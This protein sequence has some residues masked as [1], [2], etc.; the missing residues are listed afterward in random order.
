MTGEVFGEHMLELVHVETQEVHAEAEQKNQNQRNITLESQTKH[1]NYYYL[2]K[3]ILNYSVS[4]FNKKHYYFIISLF[5]YLPVDP[6]PPPPRA[7]SP[8]KSASESTI[9][10]L[11]G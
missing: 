3:L 5:N 4:D 2:C 6:N 11:I 9:S 8:P 1:V 7:V 10:T